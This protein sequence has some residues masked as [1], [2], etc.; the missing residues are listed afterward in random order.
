M[1]KIN[2]L[3]HN[4]NHGFS[5][6]IHDLHFPDNGIIGIIGENG[7]GKTT[8]MSILSGYLKPST[9]YNV[10]FST[11]EYN[12]I[13][14]P[15]DV[16]LYDFLTVSEFVQMICKYSDTTLSPNDLIELIGLTDK[17]DCMIDE[18]SLGMQKKLTLLPIFMNKSETLI[19]DEPFNSIDMNY[20]YKLKQ[21][22]CEKKQDSLIII[23]SHIIETL[24]DICDGFVLLSHGEVIKVFKNTGSVT[25]VEG[26]IFEKSN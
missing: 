17:N 20:I 11:E 16:K 23:S 14:I 4:Y 15:S 6:K 1:I 10:Q 8:L 21:L 3:I 26:E 24:V 18:L 22:L 7:S 9:E 2:E 13:F 25:Q 19:L 5:L 12:P